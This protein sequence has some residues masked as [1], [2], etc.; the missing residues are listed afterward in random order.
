MP[1]RISAANGTPIRVVIVTLDGHLATAVERASHT[2]KKA[3]PGLHLTM[4]AASEWGNDPAGI[5]R[6]IADIETGDIIIVTMM[7]MEDHINPVMPALLARRE[8]CD[9]MICCMSAGEV[10]RLTTMGSFVMSAPQSRS[11]QF[12]K[13]LSG[14]K[15]RDGSSGA[16]QM[17]MLRR[18][19]RILRY[20]P[21][22]AQDLRAY[23]LTLQYW[24][25]CSDSN[26]V[27]MVLFLVNRYAAGPR[28]ALCGSLDVA[29][30]EHYPDLGLHHP[31][32][33]DR[34]CE[35]LDALPKGPKNAVGT[36]GLLLMRSYVLADDTAHYDSVI[37]AFEARGIRVIPA[38]A[39]GLDAREAIE[40]F[41][42]KDGKPTI[43]ALVSLTGFSL[44]GGPAYNDAEAAAETLGGLDVPYIS[45]HAVEFQSL[46]EW[47]ASERGLMPV[48]STMMVAIPEIEGATGPTVFGGRANDAGRQQ[49]RHMQADPERVAMLTSRVARMI[50]LRNTPK[51][52]RKIG[53][54]IFDFPPGSGGT[55][56]AAH[57]SVFKSLFNT[58]KGLRAAGY[59]VD[60]PKNAE[61]L[62]DDILGGNAKALGAA[63][64]VHARV[65]VDDFVRNERHLAEIEEQWGPAPGKL[66]TDGSDL[67]ILG[68]SFGNVFVGVQPGFG[69]EGDPMRLMFEK[70]LAPTH[71]FAAFYKYLHDDFA[72]D[73]VLHFGTHGALEFMPGK[74]V[75]MSGTCW[76]DRLIGDMPNYY[77][78]AGNNPSEGTIAK[79]RSVATLISYMTPAVTEAGLYKDLV[80]IKDGIEHWRA[81]EPDAAEERHRLEEE[82]QKQA[83]ALELCEATPVWNGSAKI[84]IPALWNDIIELEKALIPHGLH[85][86]GETLDADARIEMLAAA[87]EMSLGAPLD[88]K[89]LRA[90]ADGVDTDTVI[91]IAKLKP[92]PELRERIA[93]LA[94]M[95]R[96]LGD[97][98]E[99][100]GIVRALDGR[101]VPPAPGGDLLRTPAV[102]P[103]GRN[104][105]GFDPYRMPNRFAVVEGARQA[106]KLL[107]RHMS[108]GHSLPETIA[109]VLWG[110][111]N[112]KSGGA[113]IAQALALM[114]AKPRFDSF[115]R[116]AGADLIPLEEMTR[117]RI[118]VVM[119]LSG[120]FRDLL[121]LHTKLLAEAA[122]LAATA[123]EAETD[124]FIRKHALAY[125]AEHD[126][127][128][129]TA[130][131]RVFSNADG[132]YGANLN[133]MIDNG[134]WADEDE[135][136][137]TFTRR[138]SFA[139][140][141]NGAPVQREALLNTILKDVDL[142][143][144]NLESV[145]V[146]ITTIDHYFDT[147]GG[148]NQSVKRARGEAAK[149]Y[150]CD[151]T[152][153]QDKVRTLT[154][155]V[156]LETR[157]R[158]LNPKWYDAMLEHGYEGVRQIEAHVTNTLGWS[159][160]TGQVGG[161]VYQQLTQTFILDEELR[162]QL[163]DLNPAASAKL[164]N[165]LLEA[166][167][168]QY[169][170][171]D[172]EMLEALQEASRQIEDKLEGIGAEAAA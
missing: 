94:K 107:E 169:W 111:D 79:R 65:S 163:T 62:R 30:P 129:E 166:S 143:Y 147:L 25:A 57:L 24:L 10:V 71:A 126:I 37:E 137:E 172:S 103:T 123:D 134:T 117:P 167:E 58:L 33:K 68:K 28:A 5:E 67:F 153:G 142:A 145:E 17:A 13:R 80:Q 132:A 97:D 146:G 152:S 6:C 19:P 156:A 122:Y 164:A 3:L 29:E 61:A 49:P 148:I 70:G 9:A 56:T 48:E 104:L 110:T 78:Y 52:D 85:V 72:A 45:A 141:R 112:L 46:D 73:A 2:L 139:Y 55:G 91:G 77:L 35:T 81:L 50:E 89:T 83:A 140:G 84:H 96:L 64:N 21:G 54:V 59:S 100:A 160:T 63:A 144:Q 102:L 38:F 149:V 82:I 40:R 69:Y 27:N 128:I 133:H 99:I 151:Q 39:V 88:A 42:T 12:L 171:P 130:A 32:A 157:S 34:V 124:N 90:I 135:L 159:A 18:L 74:Q 155:Q 119:T 20:I 75:G 47:R 158:M 93:E 44:V 26:V 136:A 106:E 86:V 108:E 7:F 154:E 41:F 53:V 1:K 51:A 120:I 31:R 131:V 113:P 43:D 127:D 92:T 23:F 109:L 8:N 162:K 87:A 15:K 66:L 4:H 115:G 170:Q 138:K 150:I 11:I 114:G 168:R 105:H 118:D 116:L 161:W 121:P 36:V 14:A 16:R 76:P 165:R 101:F 60:L 22:K 95:T 125:A 98:T